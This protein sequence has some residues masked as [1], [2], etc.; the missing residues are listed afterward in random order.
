MNVNLHVNRICRIIAKTKQ[1]LWKLHKYHE[2]NANLKNVILCNVLKFTSYTHLQSVSQYGF[3]P[4]NETAKQ[5]NNFEIQMK[6]DCTSTLV[7]EVCG[8]TFT[9]RCFVT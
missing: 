6:Y 2:P 9:S 5:H 3:K 4:Q 8:C 7:N 1:I